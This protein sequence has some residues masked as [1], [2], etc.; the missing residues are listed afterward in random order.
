MFFLNIIHCVKSA[1]IWSYSGP[2]FPVFG[3]NTERKGVSLRIQSKCGKLRTRITPNT[4]SFYTVITSTYLPFLSRFPSNLQK[5]VESKNCLSQHFLTTRKCILKVWT[6]YWDCVKTH[7]SQ[8]KLWRFSNYANTFKEK[9][10]FK[11]F[12]L[13]YLIQDTSLNLLTGFDDLR[14][15][16]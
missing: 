14:Y 6:Y 4:D 15:F 10:I 12:I 5:K 8:Q 3:L 7:Q 1:C 2:Y 13:E 9:E 16:R 11:F